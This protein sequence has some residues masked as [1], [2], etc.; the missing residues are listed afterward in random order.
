[1]NKWKYV[2]NDQLNESI[3]HN[4]SFCFMLLFVSIQYSMLLNA[5]IKMLGPKWILRKFLK[6]RLASVTKCT[7]KKL[8]FLLKKEQKSKIVFIFA[9]STFNS[10]T[11]DFNEVHN[12]QNLFWP[13]ERRGGWIGEK[14]VVLILR[15]NRSVLHTFEI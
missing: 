2:E 1:M 4:H 14:S 12:V 7:Y 8:L 3:K 9:I 13:I 10:G 15:K 6:Y 11:F 5:C